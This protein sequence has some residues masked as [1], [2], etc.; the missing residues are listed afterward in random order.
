MSVIELFSGCGGFSHGLEAAGFSVAVAYDNDPVLSSSYSRN[1]PSAKQIQADVSKLAS[2]DVYKEVSGPIIGIVGGPPCQGFSSIGKRQEDD[3]RRGLL[4]HFFRLVGEIRPSFF[5]MENVVG[6]QQGAAKEVLS[7]ALQQVSDAY[8]ISE[9]MILDASEFGAA[10]KRPRVFVIGF[11]KE[12]GIE[13]KQQN[14]V[15]YKKP[16]A[17]VADA[18]K[19]LQRAKQVS[20]P[21]HS[22]TW[23]IPSG[24]KLS[25]YAERLAS[26]DR[27]FTGNTRTKHSQAVIDRFAKVLPGGIDKVGR[28]PRLSWGGQCPTLRAGTGSDRGS[29]QSVR[30]LHPEE[31]RVITV[32]EAARLQGFPDSH[33]FHEAIWHSFRM[34][35]NSVSP[36]M[37]EA[38]FM[39][40]RDCLDRS[41]SRPHLAAE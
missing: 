41:I 29:F 13:F 14:L 32:R 39:A 31:P 24:A 3:P 33:I 12:L 20:S 36:I 17:S 22:D 10:T 2:T 35:G 21:A 19:D 18:I 23:K 26:P 7:R 30:P 6:L 15:P 16:A 1:F 25:S 37:S 8:R 5:V 28:H 38:I 9:P 27:L 34:I 11:L 40:V 4:S